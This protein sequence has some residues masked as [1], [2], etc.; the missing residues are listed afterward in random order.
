MTKRQKKSSVKAMSLTL[1]ED[2][3]KDYYKS[4]HMLANDLSTKGDAYRQKLKSISNKTSCSEMS[5]S[6]LNL[7]RTKLLREALEKNVISGGVVRSMHDTAE[8]FINQCETA[9]ENNMTAN[10][11]HISLAQDT[12]KQWLH[13]LKTHLTPIGGDF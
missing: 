3:R 4:I 5:I 12:L 11:I 2:I 6:E 13:E 7:V 10:K 1:I 9:R 8:D